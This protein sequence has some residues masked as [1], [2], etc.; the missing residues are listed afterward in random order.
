TLHEDGTATPPQSR[1]PLIKAQIERYDRKLEPRFRKTKWSLMAGSPFAFFRGTNHLFW[2]DF[3]DSKL[4][5]HFGGGKGT[6]VWICG[7]AHCDNFGSFT[8]AGGR[9][10][11]EL[12]D[13][14]EAVVADYQFD[15]W[16]LGVSLQLLG[17][18][19]NR[20]PKACDRMVL[21]CARGYWREIK[22]CHWYANVR[23][24]PWDEEQASGP[25]RQYLG[26]VRKHL[27]F[28]HMLERWT[29]TTREGP[30]F[31]IPG[32]P[33]LE[34]IPRDNA[35]KLEKAL[36]KYAREI[37]PWPAGKPRVFEVLDLARRLNA[38]IGSEGLKHLYALVR[39]GEVGEESYRILIV[40]QEVKPG[41]WEYLSKKSRRKT[42]ELCGDS[43]ALRAELGYR[44]LVRHPDGW[45]G[46]IEL[47]DGEYLVRERSPYKGLLP[48]DMMDEGVA[49]QL[50]AILAKAHCRARDSF[51]QNA[52]KAIKADKK[53]FRRQVAAIARAYA[54]Q[55]EEDYKGFKSAQMGGA[56]MGKVLPGP[57]LKIS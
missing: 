15:L 35:K 34:A 18:E 47:S 54:D 13:F 16:R 40:K 53:A 41:P 10:V 23:H 33:D 1:A 31:K 32:N 20:S 52:F 46:K 29:K 26:H 25:V 5:D 44:A 37:K 56:P 39:V 19:A 55:V 51:A 45:L 36:E 38:G 42:Q 48:A 57:G 27:G 2:S 8:D 22:S 50:G 30:R 43:Q 28:S 11:Y 3:G 12:N 6:R 4:L 21:E 14:D 49:G 24:A 17:R 9:L 7:D